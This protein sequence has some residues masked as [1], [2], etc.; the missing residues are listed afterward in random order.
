[1][2]S[3]GTLLLCRSNVEELLSL[4]DCIDA[5]EEVFRLQ[6]QGKIPASGI[7][8]VKAAQGGLHEVRDEDGVAD[9]IHERGAVSMEEE[10][11]PVLVRLLDVLTDLQE[12]VDPRVAD[13]L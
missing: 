4:P 10:V 2:Q 6:G 11:N 7:L 12:G 5:V 1:M 9:P 8:G 3:E 13:E